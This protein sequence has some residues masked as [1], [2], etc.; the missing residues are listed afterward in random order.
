M[1]RSL[2]P[3][4]LKE[5]YYAEIEAEIQRIFDKLIY[6]P[7]LEIL[8][9]RLRGLSG[10]EIQNTG[11]ALLDA[12][13]LGMVWYEDGQ[14]K[15]RFNSSITRAIRAIGGSFNLKS[16]SWSL[17]RDR[18]PTDISMAIAR[19]DNLYQELRRRM[20]V[21]LDNI[22]VQNVDLISKT[23]EKYE[24]TVDYME[25]D[26][27]HI[28][29]REKI[30]IEAKLTPAMREQIAEDWGNNLDLYIKKWTQE[31][32]L[33]LR[34]EITPHVLSGGRAQGLVKAIQDN[35]G[36]SQRKA[37][38]LARQ[39][40]ALLMSKFQETRYKDIGITRYRWSD[41]HD[42]RVRHDHHLLQGK[43]FSWDNPPVTNRRTG[44][45]NHPGQDYNCR[46]VA[47]PLV[48]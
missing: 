10:Y 1:T 18:L 8:G 36:V 23:Q 13:A 4:P 42:Q 21:T 48:E 26:F 39:E 17:S 37:Q 40:T 15:G 35:Y 20:L 34:Q 16:R 33:K 32:I 46:C 44:A 3:M 45:R 24:K 19:A 2:S 30:A 38:F 11:S 27:Q 12:I 31:N 6:K 43:I 25:T 5:H 9:M 22:D 7:L 41:S 29:A 28:T 14:F 47:V